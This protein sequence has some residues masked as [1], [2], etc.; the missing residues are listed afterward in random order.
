MRRL[1]LCGSS[2]E[3]YDHTYSKN[4][5]NESRQSRGGALDHFVFFFHE[6]GENRFIPLPYG[7]K[8]TTSSIFG[9]SSKKGMS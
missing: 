8:V 3:S 2:F 9:F 5:Q 4:I 6:T 7:S 1:G